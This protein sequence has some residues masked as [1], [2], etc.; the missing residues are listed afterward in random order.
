MERVLTVEA[1][2][3]GIR[4]DV[5]LARR[6]SEKSRVAL[7]K[8]IARGEIVCKGQ[9]VLKASAPVAEGETYIL[10]LTEEPA[11]ATLAP[12]PMDLDIIF[13]D[14]ALLVINKPAGLVV[15]PGAGNWSGTLAN[16]LA[17]RGHALSETDGMR[18]GIVHRL[19]KDTS[20]L[21]VV[22]KTD[23]AH[24]ALAQ[25]FQERTLKKIYIGLVFGT[26]P[27]QGKMEGNIGR[28]RT[29]RQKQAVLA[30]GGKPALTTFKRLKSSAHPSVSL[31][32]FHLHTGRTH[33]IR[34]HSAHAGHPILGDSVYGSPQ[35]RRLSETLGLAHQA[36]HAASLTFSHP[37][38][39]ATLAFAAPW[40]TWTGLVDAKNAEIKR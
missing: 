9:A 18:P 21:L 3:D 2:E 40:L 8:S 16:G 23:A 5:F 28:H 36:L 15:H 33:Q 24:G 20:G 26:A 31:V 27:L 6:V 34:V 38:T 29:H 4:L 32:E 13:E 7:Q 12:E 25:Q 17:A 1:D 39:G 30:L 19:D 10:A 14:D 11:A 22:A 35:S 37:T